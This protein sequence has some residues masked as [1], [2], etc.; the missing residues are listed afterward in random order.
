MNFNSRLRHNVSENCRT[1]RQVRRKHWELSIEME[2][3]EQNGRGLWVMGKRIN[4]GALGVPKEREG[5]RGNS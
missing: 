5:Y 3:A 4:K 1:R 2:N